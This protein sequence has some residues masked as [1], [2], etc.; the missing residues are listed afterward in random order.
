M[1]HWEWGQ[2]EMRNGGEGAED[3]AGSVRSGLFIK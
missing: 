1:S 2:E 3:Q